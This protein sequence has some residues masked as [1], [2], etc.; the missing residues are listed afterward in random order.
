MANIYYACCIY[1]HLVIFFFGKLI[2]YLSSLLKKCTE[3]LKS[4]NLKYSS[5]IFFFQFQP[6]V[7]IFVKS[8]QNFQN[9]PYFFFLKKQKKKKKLLEFR[10]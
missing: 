1:F 6:S 8:Y 4:V 10:Y 5:F 3:I 7:R 9:T 2:F